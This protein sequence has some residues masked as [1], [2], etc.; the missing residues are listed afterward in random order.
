MCG[1][2]LRRKGKEIWLGEKVRCGHE[3]IAT[4]VRL[5]F[6]R[7]GTAFLP[8]CPDPEGRLIGDEGESFIKVEHRP[9]GA[10]RSPGLA[11]PPQ[12]FDTVG[13]AQWPQAGNWRAGAGAEQ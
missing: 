7:S 3:G 13:L 11:P 6:A 10:R 9:E 8:S 1:R 5:G 12:N 2:P 4:F